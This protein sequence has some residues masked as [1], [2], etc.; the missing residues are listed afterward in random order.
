MPSFFE[1]LQIKNSE[2]VFWDSIEESKRLTCCFSWNKGE[3]IK[4]A[5]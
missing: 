1:N 5:A 2:H 4:Y 3:D